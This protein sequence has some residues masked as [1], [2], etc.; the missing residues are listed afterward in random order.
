[1]NPQEFYTQL[2]RWY[3]AEKRTL[4]WRDQNN[5]YY[6]LLSE[7][8]LQ[9]TTVVT[10]IPYF[11]RFIT[12]WPTLEAMAQ[13]SLDEILQQ[14]QGL[15]Y[16]ARA[17]NMHKAIQAIVQHH[18]GQIPSTPE[19]LATLPGIGP[20]T[21]AA[22]A[23]IGFD[24]PAVPVDG[25]IVRVVSRLYRCHETGEN[26]KQRVRDIVTH[27]IP[28]KRSGDFA[29][30]LMDLGARICT[31]RTPQ[32][33]HCPVS[34]HCQARHHKDVEQFPHKVTAPP[35]PKRFGITW[36]CE[37]TESQV[38]IQQKNDPGLFSG[39]W[40][41]PGSIWREEPW[42]PEETLDL[43]PTH[44]KHAETLE[45]P[46]THVFTHFHL[47][48]T[49]IKMRGE[50]P[51]PAQAVSQEAL[52]TYAMPTLMRKVITRAVSVPLPTMFPG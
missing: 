5:P 11:H 46:V 25:N 12:L 51:D 49:I 8:M 48:L 40:M 18:N 10:V 7:F 21:A 43:L 15:G 24:H 50:L 35:K 27:H 6:T 4:P 52:P 9:Q 38:Y 39:L 36:W 30:A 34:Q 28:H 1:M 31:P 32:C 44:I 16:Y 29:Q 37:P 23:A 13:A 2:L 45:R 22:I 17:R 26:L 14:W 47:T 3:D 33:T 20:Y 19:T 42:T 41:L